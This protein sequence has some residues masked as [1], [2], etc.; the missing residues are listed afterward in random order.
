MQLRQALLIHALCP[1][2][3]TATNKAVGN[4]LVHMPELAWKPF[5]GVA[6]EAAA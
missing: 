4:I 6:Q 2:L 5:R 1:H 3:S